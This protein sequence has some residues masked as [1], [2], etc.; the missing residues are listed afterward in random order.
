LLFSLAACS[1][2]NAPSGNGGNA[3]PTPSAQGGNTPAPSDPGY[4]PPISP[5]ATGQ[6]DTAVFPT[7]T[8]E[9]DPYGGMTT[10]DL[11]SRVEERYGVTII[12]GGEEASVET[13]PPWNEEPCS[14]L[15]FLRQSL[16]IMDEQLALYPEGFF[17]QMPETYFILAE[18]LRRADGS[19]VQGFADSKKDYTAIFYTAADYAFEVREWYG[20][21]DIVAEAAIDFQSTLHHE[22][23]HTVFEMTGFNGAGVFDYDEYFAILPD[24]FTPTINI[25]DEKYKKYIPTDNVDQVYFCSLYAMTNP[26]EF[27]AELFCLSMKPSL[28]WTFASPHIQAQLKLFFGAIREAYDSADWPV[29][30]YWERALR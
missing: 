30:T 3:S 15:E 21:G 8:E 2:S 23:G 20:D 25:Y 22:I 29:Q 19:V 9:Y 26:M 16:M 10:E 14:N 13:G 4:E 11:R 12:W 18:C 24:D 7:P 5:L 1:G 17:R 6:P 27:M 28:N